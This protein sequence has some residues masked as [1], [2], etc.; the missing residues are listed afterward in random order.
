MFSYTKKAGCL[1]KAGHR[2]ILNLCKPPFP[3]T[4]RGIVSRRRSACI[5]SFRKCRFSNA[6]ESFVGPQCIWP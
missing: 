5:S 1:V 2:Q 6:R 3:K 4:V